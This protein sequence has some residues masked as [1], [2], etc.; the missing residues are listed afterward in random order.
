[1]PRN[2]LAEELPDAVAGTNNKPASI[3][4]ALHVWA[5]R[6][7]SHADRLLAD[8]NQARLERVRYKGSSEKEF[9]CN[10]A[11]AA[12]EQHMQVC[13]VLGREQFYATLEDRVLSE[14]YTATVDHIG[15]VHIA[16]FFQGEWER[17][18]EAWDSF[19]LFEK[20]HLQK[21][22]HIL[23]ESE[24][25]RLGYLNRSNN[26]N[27]PRNSMAFGRRSR[28]ISDVAVQKRETGTS[29]RP[30]PQFRSG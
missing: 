20:P 17:L 27:D 4:R 24:R 29:M 3:L 12:K 2:Q 11:V 9:L 23:S 10:G 26:P 5:R 22:E 21:D 8:W 30:S 13:D 25:I 18:K 6:F 14:P 15:L 7:R 19:T 16:D 1:M 28:V